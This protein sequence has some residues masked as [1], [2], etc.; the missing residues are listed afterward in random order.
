MQ[1]II[2]ALTGY[3]HFCIEHNQ[4]HHVMVATPEEPYIRKVERE[5][6]HFRNKGAASYCHHSLADGEKTSGE[7][8]AFVLALEQ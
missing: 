3:A 1:K 5:F 8:R 4:G 6:I 7:T 2:T